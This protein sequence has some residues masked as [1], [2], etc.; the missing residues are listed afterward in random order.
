M[1]KKTRRGKFHTEYLKR[2]TMGNC[3]DQKEKEGK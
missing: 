1:T 2:V 3:D